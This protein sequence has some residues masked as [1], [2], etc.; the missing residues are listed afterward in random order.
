MLTHLGDRV[1]GVDEA[2][3]GPLAG[4]VVVAAV[5]LPSNAKLPGLN[6][7]KKL[8]PKRRECLAD[9]IKKEALAW[10]IEV[11][12]ASI[13][14]ERN[15]LGATL[16]GMQRAVEALAIVPKAVHVD[17]NQLPMIVGCPVIPEI[18][19]DGRIDCIAAASILAKVARDALMDELDGEY[20]QYGF[21]KHKGY[22]TVLHREALAQHGPCPQHRSSF[23][24][25]KRYLEM[26]RTRKIN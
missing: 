13:I 8:S 24:P 18:Q 14:D 20:P 6:D 7:S 2:G 4:P 12:S 25:V 22:P 3:R 17:G 10:S 11:V 9:Q 15:I 5:I 19:G 26:S 1:A 21:K 16:W 23:G